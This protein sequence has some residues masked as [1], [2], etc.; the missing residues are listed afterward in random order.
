[1][2]FFCLKV[3]ETLIVGSGV[4]G[5][6]SAIRQARKGLKVKVI[7]KSHTYGGK[8]GEIYSKG[9]RFDTGPSLFTMPNYVTELLDEAHKNEFNYT[10][11]ENLC[12]YFFPDQ[13][14]FVAKSNINSF[15]EDAS[16]FFKTPKKDIEAFL[17]KSE[18]IYDIT[19]PIFLQ[20]S[21][22]KLKT[23]L[24][25]DGFKGIL[26]LWQIEMFKT[27]NNKLESSFD[28][29]KL[30]Q[31][32]NRYATYNGSNPYVAPATLHVIPHLEFKYGAYL[33]KNGIRDIANILY[34]QAKSLG[35]QFQFNTQVIGST[36]KNNNI[37]TVETSSGAQLKCD[38]LIS[39]VDAKIT[40]QN[41]LKRNLPKKILNAENSSSALIFYW[42]IGKIFPEIDIHNIFFS[43][44]YQEE[45]DAI[46]NSKKLQNDPTVYIHT[47]QPINPKDAPE[48]KQN[49]FVMINTGYNRGQNW[50]ELIKEARKKI[51]DKI[52]IS[53]K[54]DIE[55]L[56][57]FEDILSPVLIEKITG[58]NKGSLYGSSS[59][60]RMSA[61]FRQ[62]NF[63]NDIKNLYFCGG[64]VHPGGGIPL[65]LL[66]ASIVDK[67]IPNANR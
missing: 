25:K 55:P 11:L 16:I 29:E 24:S 4:S 31:L 8:M 39:A 21:L 67:L 17:K 13:T 51:L 22:H 46:F 35:V 2:S 66:S 26:N 3:V 36:L 30:I 18:N 64:S 38:V 49:W 20:N 40:Y 50:N 6:A 19:A 44:E 60:D 54:E 34:K 65:C 42:G 48:G 61:F 1:M 10:R 33:P 32:F 43:K 7:E 41:I 5:L 37:Q 15:L 45:F 28:N 63:S 59:N 56:I 47:T 52:S 53:L 57:E 62:A 27:M 12:T 9:F 14:K 58:S 23:Y